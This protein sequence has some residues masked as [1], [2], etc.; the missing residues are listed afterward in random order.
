MNILYLKNLIHV[1]V[2]W[3]LQNDTLRT[4]KKKKNVYHLDI[5]YDVLTELQ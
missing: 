5:L 2:Y 4:T 1:L 3:N